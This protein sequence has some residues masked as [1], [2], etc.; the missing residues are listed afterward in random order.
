MNEME[1]HSKKIITF[2]I[3]TY[4]Q[5]FCIICVLRDSSLF[6]KEPQLVS[7]GVKAKPRGTEEG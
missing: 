2:K 6:K 3:D 1:K 4:C 5:L 7:L